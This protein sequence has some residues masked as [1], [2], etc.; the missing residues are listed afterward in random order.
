MKAAA[1]LAVAGAATALLPKFLALGYLAQPQ[2]LSFFLSRGPAVTAFAP[3][4]AA[5]L[6]FAF[7]L[8]F[9]LHPQRPGGRKGAFAAGAAG[10]LLM[11]AAHAL[12]AANYLASGQAVWLSRLFGGGTAVFLAVS[13][14]SFLCLAW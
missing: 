7:C 2:S 4:A 11:T 10:W 6:L 14:A 5:A 8:A 13:T 9:L 12:V 1:G 3:L